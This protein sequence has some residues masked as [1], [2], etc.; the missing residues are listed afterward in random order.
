MSQ[1]HV[2]DMRFKHAPFD[3]ED[4]PDMTTRRAAKLL[5]L[6]LLLVDSGLSPPKKAEAGAGPRKAREE[7]RRRGSVRRALLVV[8]LLLREDAA[9]AGSQL[10]GDVVMVLAVVRVGLWVRRGVRWCTRSGNG[11]EADKSKEIDLIAATSRRANTTHALGLSPASYKATQSTHAC[12]YTLCT[13][14][15]RHR[16][17]QLSK[18]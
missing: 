5:L 13:T 11:E 18:S 17:E 9:I 14:T 6:V 4:E 2:R 15:Q 16:Q 10:V 12:L 1:V 3:E 8:R 7:R